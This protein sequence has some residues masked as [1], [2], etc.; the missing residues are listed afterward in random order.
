MALHC[1]FV[2]QVKGMYSLVEPDGTVRVVEYWADDHH[3]F[4]AVVKKIGH[5][6]HPAPHHH[7]QHTPLHYPS[8][9]SEHDYPYQGYG[10]PS[11][12]IDYLPSKSSDYYIPSKSSD[13]Y[14]PSKSSDYV[15]PSKSLDYFPSKSVDYKK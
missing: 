6:V 4:N 7:Y 2:V 8:K 13:Y 1:L 3:G 14:T 9:S 11:K 15:V 10:Y 5:A 12:S